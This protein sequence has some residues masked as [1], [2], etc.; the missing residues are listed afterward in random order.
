MADV[1]STVTDFWQDR[2]R[3]ERGRRD[4]VASAPRTNPATEA[5]KM[6]LLYL[7]RIEDLGQGDF[8]TPCH[9]VALLTPEALLRGGLRPAA[10]VLDLKARLRC[11]GCGR[12]GRGVVSVKWRREGV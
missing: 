1:L 2:S 5:T 6:Q 9:H 8:V 11:R 4:E 10:K 7:V 3:E 12:K